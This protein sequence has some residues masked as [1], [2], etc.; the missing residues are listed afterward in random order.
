MKSAL[1][2]LS[3]VLLLPAAVRGQGQSE[4]RIDHA[5]VADVY[6]DAQRR[7]SEAPEGWVGVRVGDLLP[8]NSAVKTAGHA[9]LLLTLPDKHAIRVGENTTLELKEVGLNRSY[10]F[11]L[12]EG[13]IW[14]FVNKA[15]RPTKYEVETPS[16]I[17]G[18]S[19]TLFG[20]SFNRTAGETDMSVDEGV[21]SL[22]QGTV[23]RTVSR[24]FALR[25]R[26]DQLQQAYPVS[27]DRSIQQT[28]RIFHSRETWTRPSGTPKIAK[29]V[30][31]DV[32]ALK[33]EHEKHIQRQQEQA[34]PKAKKTPPKKPVKAGTDA[35]SSR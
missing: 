10:Y 13:E 35:A 1:R 28:W 31:A 24:G 17:L 7:V 29:E 11:Q 9:G 20:I 30:E 27:Q 21:V 34:N 33:R 16:T 32:R 15:L 5:T 12:I 8:P 18:V 2:L 23:N 4:P 19:G 6:G 22:R 25:V 3:L 26:R 14:S